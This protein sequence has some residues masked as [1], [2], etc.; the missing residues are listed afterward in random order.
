M[1]RFTD[2]ATL[3]K[4]PAVVGGGYR[5]PNSDDVVAQNIRVGLR[6]IGASLDR[7]GQAEQRYGIIADGRD[8]VIPG[9]RLFVNRVEYRIVAIAATSPYLV[10]DCVR[11]PGDFA[12]TAALIVNNAQLLVNGRALTVE[13]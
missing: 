3:A 10:A 13:R 11:L 1:P 6:S 5:F 9:M 4:E 2:T 7:G 12:A 8:D